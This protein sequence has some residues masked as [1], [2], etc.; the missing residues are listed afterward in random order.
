[1]RVAHERMHAS[2]DRSFP[3]RQVIEALGR[4]L[5][6]HAPAGHR[7]ASRTSG[8][9]P[10]DRPAP[11]RLHA[12]VHLSRARDGGVV[13][14]PAPTRRRR[15]PRCG[16]FSLQQTLD[17][18][19]VISTGVAIRPAEQW[20]ASNGCRRDAPARRA[21]PRLCGVTTSTGSIPRVVVSVFIPFV[22]RVL[23][24]VLLVFFTPFVLLRSRRPLRARGLRPG[25]APPWRTARRARPSGPTR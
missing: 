22:F 13:G 25:G 11:D 17:V 5:A 14:T 6:R 21:S 20:R 10:F 23:F 1:M 9:L 18:P 24:A 7:L 2:R 4:G 12:R 15:R 16:G 8:P 19:W 3:R